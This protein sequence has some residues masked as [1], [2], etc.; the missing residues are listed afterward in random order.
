MSATAATQL[1]RLAVLA[2][3]KRSVGLLWLGQSSVALRLAGRTVLVDPFLSPHLA[4]N[5]DDFSPDGEPNQVLVAGG[6][7]LQ[8]DEIREILVVKL[9]HIGDCII[10]FPA[11]RRLRQCF[12]K[13]RIT[14]LTSRAWFMAPWPGEQVRQRHEANWYLGELRAT[15]EALRQQ[16]QQLTKALAQAQD[17]VEVMRRA[18]AVRQEDFAVERARRKAL[19]VELGAVRRYGERRRAVR[20]HGSD[21]VAEV[22]ALDGLLLFHG[23]PPDISLTGLAFAT[24]RA[25]DEAPDFVE[26]TLHV[27]ETERPIEALGRLVWRDALEGSHQW[28]CE[29]V[30]LLPDSRK[31]LEAALATTTSAPPMLQ[32]LIIVDARDSDLYDEIR[33]TWFGDATVKVITDRRRRERRQQAEPHRP[34]RRRGE[35]RRYAITAALLTERWA[36]VPLASIRGEER[37]SG[38]AP[39]FG[40]RHRS[41]IPATSSSS[42]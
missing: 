37:S 18:A 2:A 42:G 15:H 35:R 22:R 36:E 41:S 29:L 3:A 16:N 11:L 5:Q 13:A 31:S 39:S 9:D 28:G 23:S 24:D 27:P 38:E 12:P 40:R 6:P 32:R 20:I 1:D 34:E 19:E 21:I 17:D 4:R 26:I 33:R 10:A 7:V 14:V 25:I 8:R 30:D